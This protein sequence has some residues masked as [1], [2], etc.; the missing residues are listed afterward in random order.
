ME[1][2]ISGA[3]QVVG[4]VIALANRIRGAI[5][6]VNVLIDDMSMTSIGLATAKEIVGARWRVC[7]HSARTLRALG[8]GTRR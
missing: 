1:L 4:V 8:E 5:A 7:A 2:A 6:E 3:Q